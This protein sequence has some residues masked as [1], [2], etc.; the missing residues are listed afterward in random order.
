M[1]ARRFAELRLCVRWQRRDQR[2]LLRGVLLTP[3]ELAAVRFMRTAEAE[4]I[5]SDAMLSAA[6]GW[7]L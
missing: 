5:G 3:G 2:Y 7:T 4:A 6:R 1:N